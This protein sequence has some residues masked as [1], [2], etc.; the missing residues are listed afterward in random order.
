MEK[1]KNNYVML[2]YDLMA[3]KVFADQND[4]EPIKLLIELILGIKADKISILSNEIID[5]PYINKEN[6]VDILVEVDDNTM[7]V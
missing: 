5:K 4:I 7:V 1:S 6:E 2:G 3:K